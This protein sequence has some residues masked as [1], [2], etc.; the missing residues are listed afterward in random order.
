MDIA[1]MIRIIQYTANRLL[2]EVEAPAR[3]RAAHRP[4]KDQP[5]S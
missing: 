1:Y 3:A 5:Q 2:Q 4:A